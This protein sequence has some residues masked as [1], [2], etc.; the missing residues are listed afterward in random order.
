MTDLIKKV[1]LN[2]GK[3]FIDGKLKRY[4][5]DCLKEK[6][7]EHLKS[8][9]RRKGIKNKNCLNCGCELTKYKK[10]YCTD[11][12][13]KLGIYGKSKD[14][15]KICLNCGKEFITKK[16][17]VKYCSKSCQYEMNIKQNAELY[18]INKEKRKQEKEQEQK[19]TNE[20]LIAKKRRE[21][22]WGKYD[23]LAKKY[24]GYYAF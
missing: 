12:A 21:K 10:K 11:C 24:G 22:I 4:C 8:W 7:R 3:E 6:R 19:E 23:K 1:C 9:Q 18:H 15:K 16:S 13:E 5:H 20:E 2:C 17:V 14:I